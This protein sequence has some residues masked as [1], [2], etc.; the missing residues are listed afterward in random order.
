MLDT[1]A[2]I[3]LLYTLMD[4]P[5]VFWIMRDQFNSVPIE[6]EEAALVDGPSIWG[7]FFLIVLPVVVPGIA[8]SFIFSTIFC[9]NEYFFASLL[10][11]THATTLPAMVAAQTCSQGVGWRT[12]A[13][14]T[15]H[16]FRR[17]YSWG[18]SWNA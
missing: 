15:G 16:R 1:L 13:A 8:A 14:L 3:V 2:G 17:F 5:I 9:W 4:L 7:A 11:S 18:S 10:A 12:I 6:L